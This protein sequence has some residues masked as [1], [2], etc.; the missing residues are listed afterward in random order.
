MLLRNDIL[1]AKPEI[2]E[3]VYKKISEDPLV[4]DSLFYYLLRHPSNQH[5]ASHCPKLYPSETPGKGLDS[6]QL[7]KASGDTLTHSI[8][9]SDRQMSASAGFC[10]IRQ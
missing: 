8:H 10:S 4:P 6:N 7:R 9:A 1:D 3:P 2:L 5:L